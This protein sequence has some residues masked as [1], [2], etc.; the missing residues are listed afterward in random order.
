MKPS[1]IHYIEVKELH[2]SGAQVLVD[3]LS[4]N[5]VIIPVYMTQLFLNDILTKRKSHMTQGLSSLKGI[6]SNT[7]IAV[8][9]WLHDV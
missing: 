4:Y 1:V 7:I 9:P 8:F 3:H 2:D 5:N 6:L